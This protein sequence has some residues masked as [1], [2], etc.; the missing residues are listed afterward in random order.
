MV[1]GT[2]YMAAAS[3]L[4]PYDGERGEVERGGNKWRSKREPKDVA[5]M[6]A[7]LLLLSHA[8]AGT[9]QLTNSVGCK[10]KLGLR[11]REC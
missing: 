11:P 9:G 4:L 3:S 8:D 10:L 6:R 7:G 1:E 2:G 5:E